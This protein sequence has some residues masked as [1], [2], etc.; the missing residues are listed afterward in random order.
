M[1][2]TGA[3]VLPT[4]MRVSAGTLLVDASARGD[5]D[6]VLAGECAV[7]ACQTWP[8]GHALSLLDGVMTEALREGKDGTGMPAWLAEDD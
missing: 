7:G 4:T 3:A 1:P 6:A 5:V 8:H 2:V